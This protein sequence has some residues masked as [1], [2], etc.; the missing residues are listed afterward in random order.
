[1][2]CLSTQADNPTMGE[3]PDKARSQLIVF[4][5]GFDPISVLLHELTYQAMVQDLLPVEN[6]VYK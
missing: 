4:D 3:G 2:R 6:D 1:M 5:R